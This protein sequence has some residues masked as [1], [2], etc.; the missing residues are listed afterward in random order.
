MGRAHPCGDRLRIG[1]QLCNA[2]HAGW[3]ARV[4]ATRSVD[5]RV[6]DTQ[7]GCALARRGHLP[8]LLERRALLQ[9]RGRRCNEERHAHEAPQHGLYHRVLAALLGLASARLQH[10][11]E[12]SA[13]SAHRAAVHGAPLLC[14]AG[15]AQAGRRRRG[16]GANTA[17][18]RR[19]IGGLGT[20]HQAAARHSHGH[21]HHPQPRRA[22]GAQQRLRRHGRGQRRSRH[23]GR[24]EGGAAV[25]HGGRQPRAGRRAARRDGRAGEL[26]GLH[27]APPRREVGGREPPALE[28]IPAARPRRQRPPQKRRR[29]PAAGAP[30]AGGGAPRPQRG[31]D[32]EGH[33]RGRRRARRVRGVPEGPGPVVQ[34]GP[35]EGRR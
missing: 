35:R 31:A 14:E 19:E 24:G 27:G 2:G 20:P 4:H 17:R 10:A 15:V 23:R 8:D 9:R 13:R 33:G 5:K 1:T 30:R 12:G 18:G 28:G 7:G 26:H 32:D 29:G 3:D 34:V 25:Q 6:V 16:R 11:R 21:R 22:P